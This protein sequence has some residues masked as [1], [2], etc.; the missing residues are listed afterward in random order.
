MIYQVIP[1]LMKVLFDYL[2]TVKPRMD[3]G[4]LNWQFWKTPYLE[5]SI[6]HKLTQN[7]WGGTVTNQDLRNNVLIKAIQLYLDEKKIAFKRAQVTFPLQLC[8][9]K[10]E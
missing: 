4:D 3:S 1:I 5:R 6:E 7:S 8:I 2:A 10:F 9:I